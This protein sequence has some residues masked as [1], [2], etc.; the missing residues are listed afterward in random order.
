MECTTSCCQISSRTTSTAFLQ[1]N[2]LYF[3]KKQE[4]TRGESNKPTAGSKGFCGCRKDNESQDS[5]FGIWSLRNWVYWD[6][7][8]FLILLGLYAFSVPSLQEPWQ[9]QA[10]LYML[11]MVYG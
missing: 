3:D 8:V 7:A 11:R 6:V 9:H 10:L 5:R 1:L 4:E 2:R